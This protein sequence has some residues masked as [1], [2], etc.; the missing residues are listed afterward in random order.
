[1]YYTDILN[2]FYTYWFCIIHIICDVWQKNMA[3]Y[4]ESYEQC[5]AGN[6]HWG[7]IFA[8]FVEPQIQYTAKIFNTYVPYAY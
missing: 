1:M 6:I 3:P 5:I 7:F 2:W 8:I 4:N